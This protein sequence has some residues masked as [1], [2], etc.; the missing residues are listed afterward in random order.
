MNVKLIYSAIQRS[1]Y[2][3]KKCQLLYT[4]GDNLY[5]GAPVRDRSE[6]HRRW[7]SI[8]AAADVTADIGGKSV[9][10]TVPVTTT[11]R[12]TA[13][14]LAI[15]Q[16]ARVRFTACQAQDEIVAITIA[17]PRSQS[18]KV[19]VLAAV[20][21]LCPDC[22]SFMNDQLYPMFEI[23]GPQVV[24][25]TVVSFG[26]AVIDV[27]SKRVDCQHGPAECDANSYEQCAASLYPYP[28]R[29]LR[30]LRCLD[31]ELEMGHRDEP[32]STSLFAGCAR[33]SALDFAPI[34][35]CH[36]D[37]EQAWKLQRQ[38]AAATPQQHT[39]VPWIEINGIHS[40]D[41]TQDSLLAAVCRAY[42]DGGGSHPACRDLKATVHVRGKKSLES[43]SPLQLC[44]AILPPSD[45]EMVNAA[46]ARRD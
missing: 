4:R 14:A 29:Y 17:D 34:K 3:S 25:L 43:S 45:D 46:Q 35:A 2:V 24:D 7:D 10:K 27:K 39:Y 9:R 36:D 11:M 22:R 37:P 16:L 28:E 15:F 31:N 23:L 44:H 26:N 5:V 33:D 13:L 1:R 20:E 41:E 42:E 12:L 40:M 18:K 6:I 38:A 19:H 8:D 32:F 30:Y 21:A